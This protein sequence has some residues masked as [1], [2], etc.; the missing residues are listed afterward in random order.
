[1]EK[2]SPLS[3]QQQPE[4]FIA[5]GEKSVGP[6]SAAEIYERVIAGDLTWISYV[7][8]EGMADWQRVCDVPT[9]QAAVPAKPSAKPQAHPP[10]APSPKKVQPKECFLYYNDSQHGPFSE[11]EVKG[12][13]GAGKIDAEVFAWRDGM[14]DW[15]RIASLSSFAGE[16]QAGAA[17]SPPAAGGSEKRLYSR[18]PILAKVMIAEGDKIIV[19]VGRDISIGGMQVLSDYVPSRVGS[20]LKLNVSP[21]DLN[22]PAFQAF[23]AE[24]VVV[25]IH[26]DRRGFSFRFDELGGTT[27]QVIERLLVG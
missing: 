24:G 27:R 25:R 1:M 11:D 6:V 3:S 22:S 20:K 16:F 10:G 15:E 21:P 19:G 18:K 13:A 12:M 17:H 14:A 23:V 26:E 9:F 5:V 8:K 4:W 2:R 7:W